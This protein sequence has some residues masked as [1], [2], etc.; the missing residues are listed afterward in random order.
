MPR[1]LLPILILFGSCSQPVEFKRDNPTDPQSNTYSP[2]QPS[3]PLLSFDNDKR[4]RLAWQV[5]DVSFDSFLIERKTTLDTGFVRLAAVPKNITAYVD[6]TG[7]LTYPMSYR[8][9]S[10]LHRDGK[11]FKTY[12]LS[13]DVQF[14]TIDKPLISY[15]ATT[16]EMG[17]I[18]AN[19]F[20]IPF[21]VDYWVRRP[22][23]QT[24]EKLASLPGPATNVLRTFPV[25]H[26]VFRLDVAVV[27]SF[28]SNTHR[29]LVDSVP[30]VMPLHFPRNV[31]VTPMTEARGRIVWTNPFTFHDDI[32]LRVNDDE[33]ILPDTTTSLDLTRYFRASI[34]YSIRVQYRHNGDFSQQTAISKTMQITA[35]SISY[36]GPANPDPVIQVSS[37]NSGTSVFNFGEYYVLEM[38]RDLAPYI[39]ID[40]VKVT[41]T[42]HLFTVTGLDTTSSYMFRARSLTSG[43]STAI[44]LRYRLSAKNQTWGGISN[45][46]NIRHFSPYDDLYMMDGTSTTT[47]IYNFD[48]RQKVFDVPTQGTGKP[49]GF[50]NKG[51]YVAHIL[52]ESGQTTLRHYSSDG[53]HS[54]DFVIPST[55]YMIGQFDDVLYLNPSRRTMERVHLPTQQTTEVQAVP[56]AP[57]AQFAQSGN[58]IVMYI[59]TQL[60]I[61]RFSESV[62]YVFV[63]SFNLPVHDSDFSELRITDTHI[64]LRT[65]KN[66]T[67]YFRYINRN[68]G[69]VEQFDRV[70]SSTYYFVFLNDYDWMIYYGRDAYFVDLKKNTQTQLVF[71]P[72][73]NATLAHPLHWVRSRDGEHDIYL[74]RTVGFSNSNPQLLWLTRQKLWVQE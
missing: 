62:G 1:L 67:N 16:R 63:N 54:D 51:G 72:V 15:N 70:L 22:G 3:K 32:I 71:T 47:G 55:S 68:T 11:E 53:S 69:G 37:S 56:T 26:D 30:F 21:I 58:D 2:V 41:A 35:P 44:R 31:N 40:S 64:I 52:E 50:T 29:S 33:W 38:S 57:S 73:V 14:G 25:D 4:N 7:F 34:P 13:T 45:A 43:P 61:Y 49:N 42:S 65:R 5:K 8:V 28:T 60:R 74:L 17:V 59:Q 23:Q 24:Y 27:Y 9:A 19:T 20:K 12:S 39:P 6:T 36:L 66:S 18:F 48:T 46:L 10:V